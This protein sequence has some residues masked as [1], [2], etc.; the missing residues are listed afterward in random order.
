[1]SGNQLAL[2]AENNITIEQFCVWYKADGVDS[3]GYAV[4]GSEQ[5]V[6]FEKD[7]WL[8]LDKSKWSNHTFILQN[9]AK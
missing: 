8:E 1:M 9:H 4:T 7:L 6:D 3:G 2:G 5:C